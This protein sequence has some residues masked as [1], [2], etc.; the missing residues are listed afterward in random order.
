MSNATKSATKYS[1]TSEIDGGIFHTPSA[2][3]SAK[4]NDLRAAWPSNEVYP[5]EFY[6]L[7]VAVEGLR[8]SLP[9]SGD[10]WAE[11]RRHVISAAGAYI[12]A[13]EKRGHVEVANLL[14]EYATA[15]LVLCNRK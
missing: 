12:K 15:A 5:D 1:S 9:S 7:A 11:Q 10:L 13:A 14:A 8:E 4:I 3:T 2:E 6:R